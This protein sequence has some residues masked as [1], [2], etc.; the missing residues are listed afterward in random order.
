MSTAH[1]YGTTGST[2][3]HKSKLFAATLLLLIGSS[4][5][6][7]QGDLLISPL[8]VIFE[9]SKKSQEISL[10]NVGKDS[11][12]YSVSI[13]DIRMKDDGSFETI[14]TPDTGQRFA[15]P[16]MRFFPRKVTLAPNE[17]QVVKIQLMK[18]SSMEPGEYRSHLYFRAV[19]DE[20]PLGDKTPDKDSTK[21][22]IQLKPIFGITT[23]VIIRVGE[24]NAD[25]SLS[26]A[27]I[28]TGENKKQIVGLTFNRTGN[29]S[30]YGDLAIQYVSTEGKT[31]I[32]KNVK[33]IGVY[34]PNKLRRF[35]VELDDDKPFDLHKGKIR[36]VYTL[37][38]N[39]KTPV[40]KETEIALK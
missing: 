18:T 11:A 12:T 13:V 27:N 34:T 15:G 26:D 19:P 3:L 32:L 6:F 21:I 24:N 9:G 36:I 35:R 16:Y 7:A 10:A 30:V 22:S 40:V 37:Q 39:D 2:F 20:K 29:M 8:R 25:V 17:S 28:T 14:T 5:A 23:P 1:Q 33:G 4:T 38:T 31:T